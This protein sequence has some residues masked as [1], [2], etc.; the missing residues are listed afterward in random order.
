MS[1]KAHLIVK[2][3]IKRKSR[4][5]RYLNIEEDIP[6]QQLKECGGCR[7]G[8]SADGVSLKFLLRVLKKIFDDGIF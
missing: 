7:A 6:G 8:V 2:R 5:R 1:T 3:L 4:K